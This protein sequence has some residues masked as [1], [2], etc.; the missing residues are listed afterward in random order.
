MCNARTQRL[1]IGFFLVLC[2]GLVFV[3]LLNLGFG[4]SVVV[5]G[6]PSLSID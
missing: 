4:F 2:I 1:G 5:V 3:C 6:R